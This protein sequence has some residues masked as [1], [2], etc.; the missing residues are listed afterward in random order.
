MFVS[1]L[2][3]LGA[4]LDKVVVALVVVVVVVFLVV[5]VVVTY[6]IC[7]TCNTFLLLLVKRLRFFILIRL[8]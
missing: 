1:R 7:F 6:N 2:V 4:F 3:F 8:R 5:E